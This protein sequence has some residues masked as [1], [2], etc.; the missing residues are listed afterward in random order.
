MSFSQAIM[1]IDIQGF[2]HYAFQCAGR[3][4]DTIHITHVFMEW[5]IMRDFYVSDNHTS[6]DKLL[7]EQMISFFLDRCFRPY[8]L[9]FEGAKPLDA[10][11][12]GL[13][14][15]NMVWLQLPNSDEQSY[16]E[17]LHYKNW[18]T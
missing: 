5:E 16:L 4:F 17:R 12:W 1:K 14:P 10:K 7:V 3:L 15:L 2:E 11:Q 18:P 9:V 6:R 13:W 8:K